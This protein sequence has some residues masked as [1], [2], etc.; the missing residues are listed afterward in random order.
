L[1]Y[2]QQARLQFEK[3]RAVVVME[4]HGQAKRVRQA[5]PMAFLSLLTEFKDL[6]GDIVREYRVLQMIGRQSALI[7]GLLHSNICITGPDLCTIAQDDSTGCAATVAK[8]RMAVPLQPAGGVEVESIRSQLIAQVVGLFDS[9]DDALSAAVEAV[10]EVCG[11]KWAT[12]CGAFAVQ[13]KKEYAALIFP[14]AVLQYI[15]YGYR[16]T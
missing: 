11:K 7:A 13:A 2:N 6:V 1:R 14:R 8:N 5:G 3:R 9:P 12:R 16:I 10:F 15:L 4:L